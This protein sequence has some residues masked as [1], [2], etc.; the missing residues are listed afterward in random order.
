MVGFLKQVETA[1]ALSNLPAVDRLQGVGDALYSQVLDGTAE[2][3]E[4][5][6]EF[7]ETINDIGTSDWSN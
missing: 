2:P 3:V 1:V 4:A 6:K 5:V 7:I